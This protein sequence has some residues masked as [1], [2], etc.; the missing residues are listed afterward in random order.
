MQR[1]RELQRP[2]SVIDNEGAVAEGTKKAHIP[3]G[4]ALFL[5]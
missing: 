5:D 1:L 3:L 4:Y 2:F